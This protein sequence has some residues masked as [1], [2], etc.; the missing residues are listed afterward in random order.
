MDNEKV[1]DPRVLKNEI[2]GLS[3]RRNPFFFSF[4]FFYSLFQ[5]ELFLIS[6]PIRK[7]TVILACDVIRLKFL[8]IRQPKLE[9][10]SI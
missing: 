10:L 2:I 6:H 4:F 5:V 1:Y 3:L 9:K 7:V 8:E